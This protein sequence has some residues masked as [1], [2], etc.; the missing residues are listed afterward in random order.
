MYVLIVLLLKL[1]VVGYAFA[2]GKTQ[3]LYIE[4]LKNVINV[5]IVKSNGAPL[6]TRRLLSDFEPAL[7]NA[8]AAL[9][10]GRNVGCEFHFEQALIRNIGE[11]GL[12]TELRVPVVFATFKLLVAI[13]LGEPQDAEEAFKVK[14]LLIYLYVILKILILFSSLSFVSS[15]WRTT[16]ARK[17]TSCPFRPARSWAISSPTLTILG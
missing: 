17:G 1:F 2:T 13:A 15:L 14:Y 7:M 9:F 6:R 5:S 11:L 8:L 3:L 12:R 10:P 16:S 4:I